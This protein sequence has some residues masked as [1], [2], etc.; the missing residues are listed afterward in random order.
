MNRCD[1]VIVYCVSWLDR[2]SARIE[3]AGMVSPITISLFSDH[4]RSMEVVGCRAELQIDA[5]D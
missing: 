3:Y 1:A 5:P 2:R 4:G